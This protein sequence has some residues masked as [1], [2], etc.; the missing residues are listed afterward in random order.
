MERLKRGRGFA[1]DSSVNRPIGP[2]VRPHFTGY[3]DIALDDAVDR[4]SRRSPVGGSILVNSNP[5]AHTP[6]STKTF[7]E[8]P[9]EDSLRVT[10][11]GV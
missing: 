4:V 1:L 9:R 10:E 11:H 8:F 7:P 6:N 3:P 5:P 2:I